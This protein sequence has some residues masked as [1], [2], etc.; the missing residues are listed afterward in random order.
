MTPAEADARIILSRQTLHRYADMT[1]A[2]Q[3]PVADL[4]MMA[5][6][7]AMLE[8]IAVDHP[9]K[10]EKVYRLAESWGAMADAVRGKLN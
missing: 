2:G 6:E 5:D 1:R 10:A 7:V 4:P 3:W 9:V 8:Q